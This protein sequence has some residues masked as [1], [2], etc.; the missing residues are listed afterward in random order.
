M[1]QCTRLA[2]DAAPSYDEHAMTVPAEIRDQVLTSS[3]RHCCVCHRSVGL[4]IEVHHIIQKADSGSDSLDNLIAL[5]FEC[6]GAAGH[7]NARH[8]RG[9]R[10]SPTELR[11]A[12]DAWYEQVQSGSLDGVADGER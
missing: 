9:T 4:Y 8:A 11:R 10:Y 12:R 2:P 7:Y 6:H 1:S 3:A 5:C